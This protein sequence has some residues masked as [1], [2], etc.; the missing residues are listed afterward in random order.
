MTGRELYELYTQLQYDMNACGFD[1]WDDL[2][3]S[4]REVWDALATKVRP[5]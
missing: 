5:A 3:P 1:D 4:D 2:A